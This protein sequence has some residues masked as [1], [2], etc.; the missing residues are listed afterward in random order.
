MKTKDR[1]LAI[2]A[3]SKGWSQVFP[4]ASVEDVALMRLLRVTSLG[5]AAFVDPVL[6]GSGLTESSYHTLIVIAASGES[7]TT[8]STLCEQV[9][10]HHANMTRILRVLANEKLVEITQDSRDG[11]RR[12]VVSTAAGN[13]LVQSNAKRLQPVIQTA[14]SALNT[15]DKRLLRDMLRSLIESMDAAERMVEA[16]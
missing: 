12:H 5:I 6:R 13:M 10:Q 1:L 11:R 16:P 14:L 9:G 15:A 3:S 8:P 7:G 4:D 2:E